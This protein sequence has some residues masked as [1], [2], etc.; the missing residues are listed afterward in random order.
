M[1][2]NSTPAK[3]GVAEPSY[4]AL[5][6]ALD[7][8]LADERPELQAVLRDMFYQ[9]LSQTEAAEAH[10]VHKRRVRPALERVRTKL[11]RILDA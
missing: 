1:A 3:G 2:S 9:G 8:V 11:R 7:H 5:K 6:D 4:V 10:Q